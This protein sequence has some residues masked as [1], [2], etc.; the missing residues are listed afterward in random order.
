MNE[1]KA[2]ILILINILILFVTAFV[3]ACVLHDN[4]I[5]RERLN[6]MQQAQVEQEREIKL[7]KTDAEIALRV[8][9]TGEWEK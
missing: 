9:M 2:S 8:V 6:A 3:G 1:L 4:A 7:A 5:M